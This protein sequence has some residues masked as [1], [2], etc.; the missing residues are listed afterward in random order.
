MDIRFHAPAPGREI[1]EQIEESRQS[2]GLAIAQL[3]RRADISDTAYHRLLRNPAR[4]P[5]FRTINKLKAALAE[6]ER[7]SS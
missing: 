4:V 5:N 6:F 1:F 3:C 7:P 2:C